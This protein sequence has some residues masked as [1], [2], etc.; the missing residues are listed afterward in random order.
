VIGVPPLQSDR[1]P[2]SPPAAWPILPV[3]VAAHFSLV[4][5]RAADDPALAA[6][7]WL[8]ALSIALA[9]AAA[10]AIARSR[11]LAAVEAGAESRRAGRRALAAIAAA[12]VA[13][14]LAWVALVPTAPVSDFLGYQRIAEMVA[15]GEPI[16]MWWPIGAAVASWGYP[17]VLGL[18]L[19]TLGLTGAPILALELC[20]VALGVAALLLVHRVAWRVA[21]SGAAA[22]VAAAI[23]ALWPGQLYLTSVLATEHLAVPL[24]LTAVLLL[25]ELLAPASAPRALDGRTAV[26]A[27]LCGL[28][29]AACMATRSALL[30]LP[31]ALVLALWRWRSSATHALVLAAIVVA[32]AAG[33]TLAWRASLRAAYGAAPLPALWWTV[34]TGT[35][36]DSSGSF[37]S[38]D[39]DRF[40]GH[41]SI[42]EADADARAEIASRL[43]SQPA[44]LAR[45][46]WQKTIQLWAADDYAWFWSTERF[47]G[48]APA[49]DR[50][51]LAWIAQVAHLAVLL[52][53]IGGCL[54]VAR[55]VWV[56]RRAPAPDVALLVIALGTLTHAVAE[57]QARYHFVLEP[58]AIALAAL[59]AAGVRTRAVDMA[60]TAT[61][62]D[63]RTAEA[64]R[65]CAPA[66]STEEAEKR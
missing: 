36:L 12:L 57:S 53:A 39:R 44:A 17:V 9:C 48:P 30:F 16:A 42:A 8:S 25:T 13:S 40:F 18:V 43:R 51:A 61:S 22:L 47:R 29:A 21:G 64:A 45:L 66:P 46:A 14:R 20:N 63:L 5:L 33:G 7:P 52:L 50:A 23:F 62:P 4:A 56:G 60:P 32:T 15:A 11:G 27:A 49:I 59:G 6:R 34:L 55:G 35:N 65:A 3:A 24:V 31:V 58:F 2:F 19:R 37:S 41:R 26:R 38:D 1:T 10:V 28:A 54:A